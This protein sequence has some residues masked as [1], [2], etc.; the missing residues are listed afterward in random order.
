MVPPSH[1]SQNITTFF[2]NIVP[3]LSTS[4]FQ[5]MFSP[6]A[7]ILGFS[8][9]LAIVAAVVTFYCSLEFF[10]LLHLNAVRLNGP[11][12]SGYFASC[13]V[14]ADFIAI[15]KQLAK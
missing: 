13:F 11:S 2:D 5:V 9:C 3:I 15:T 7:S 1:I 10:I 14:I 4:N 6:K 12:K 8:Q